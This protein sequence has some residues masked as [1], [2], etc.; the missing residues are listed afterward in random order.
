MQFTKYLK[1]DSNWKTA[2]SKSY[3][4]HYWPGSVS[5]L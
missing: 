3:E 5:E 1:F 2:T 4:S